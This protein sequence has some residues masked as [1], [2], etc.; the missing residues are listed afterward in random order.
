VTA[1][2]DDGRFH[3]AQSH[4]NDPL[5]CAIAKEVI[6]VL[7]EE[8]LVERS[9]RVGAHFLQEL[10]ALGARHDVVTDLR[11]RGLM[12]AIEFSETG[13]FSLAE[14]HRRLAECGYIAGYK[15]A[16]HLLRFYPPMTIGEEDI[17]GFVG[18]L[19]GVLREGP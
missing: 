1:H 11:G 14:V 5:A 17:T 7:Q 12:I 18:S 3:Y 10:K 9:A 8:E 2:L 4:Q 15:P 6:K 19:E 16:A 13:G